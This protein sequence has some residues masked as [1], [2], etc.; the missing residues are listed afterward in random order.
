MVELFN[1]WRRELA[2][3]PGTMEPGPA[4]AS[5]LAERDLHTVTNTTC[6]RCHNDVDNLPNAVQT[7][8]DPHP[9]C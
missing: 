2:R 8:L 5:R 3:P 1:L 4:W 9:W 6:A 7:P